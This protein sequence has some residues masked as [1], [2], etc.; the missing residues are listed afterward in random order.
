MW[1]EKPVNGIDFVYWWVRTSR[2]KIEIILKLLYW[3]YNL[4]TNGHR[5]PCNTSF[6]TKCCMESPF[7]ASFLCFD[8][9]KHQ[10]LRWL[11]SAISIFV[12][13]VVVVLFS[14]ESCGI[15]I[16]ALSHSLLNFTW[17]SNFMQY[18]FIL[19]ADFMNISIMTARKNSDPNW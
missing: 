7:L 14:F 12:V 17:E 8:E 4:K 10:N 9:Y 2:F 6:P 15:A 16:C 13:V 19:Y 3:N 5:N 11:P 18:L 1:H